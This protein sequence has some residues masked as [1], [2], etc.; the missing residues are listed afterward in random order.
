[1]TDEQLL[2]IFLTYWNETYSRSRPIQHAINTHVGF[3]RYLL[4]KIE[5]KDQE[6][7]S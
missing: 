3:G 6:S 7:E 1:M 4:N 2:E 5:Q